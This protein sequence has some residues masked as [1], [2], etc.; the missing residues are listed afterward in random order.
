MLP[1]MTPC[2]ADP[3]E[4]AMAV[5]LR[6]ISPEDKPFLF[7][8]YA[9]TPQGE[10]AQV[11]WDEAQKTAFL[12]MQ[13]A[14]QHSYYQEHYPHTAFQVILR[15]GQPVGRL[16]VYRGPTEM[17]IVDIALL[18]AY[19]NEGIGSSLLRGLMEEA[20]QMGKP[21][22]IHVEKNNP[23]LRLYTRLGFRAIADRGVYWFLEWTP[24]APPDTA[25]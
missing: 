16:Y 22:R 3:L 20:A 19:R 9:S 12:Q 14:A 6:P 8:V 11:E 10:L 2:P 24:G 23:A 13:F 1:G 15:D 17:R 7:Q 21:L 25:S 5:T 18:P 4:N